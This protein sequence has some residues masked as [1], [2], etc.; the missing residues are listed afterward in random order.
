MYA[1]HQRVIPPVVVHLGHLV[2]LIYRA[3]RGTGVPA[4][5]IHFMADPPHLVA[6]PEGDQ[7]Y[8]IGGRYRVTSRG[9]EG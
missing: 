6:N 1:R 7:L 9:I 3:D 4:A 2:G 5:Y 8:I